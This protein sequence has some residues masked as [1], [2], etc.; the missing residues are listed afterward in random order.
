M[1]RIG[2]QPVAIPDKVKI[3]LAGQAI[4]VTGPKGTLSR[5]LH[6]KMKIE[7]ADNEIRVS[8]SSDARSQRA[9]HGLTRQLIFNMVEG[10]TNGFEKTL[11]IIGV[12]YRAEL[13]GKHLRLALGFS[14]PI[15][16]KA[17]EGI[18]LELPEAGKIK[19]S[20]INKELVGQVAAKIRGFRPPEPYKGKG[21]RYVGE[22]VRRKA[23]KTAA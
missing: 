15:I 18:A 8:R 19:I 13:L 12:G 23:G 6:P 5:E 14:H 1:S 4:T 16:V 7:I 17:P 11:E 9:L 20:G 22:Y 21:I 3:D 2:K 10:V